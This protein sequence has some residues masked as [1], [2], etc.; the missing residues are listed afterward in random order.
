MAYHPE[1]PICTICGIRLEEPLCYLEEL[2]ERSPDERDWKNDV[3]ALSGPHWSPGESP[4][5]DLADDAVHRFDAVA[6][7]HPSVGL[8]LLPDKRS[9][10]TQSRYESDKPNTLVPPATM[11]LF[12]G[13]HAACEE[14]ANRVMRTSFN[15]RVRS[16]GHLWMTL[17]RRCARPM[18]R[19]PHMNFLP[20]LPE[21]QSGQPRSFGTGRYFVPYSCII[22][23]GDEW[24]GW[25]EDD[26]IV[27]PDLT[28]QLLSNLEPVSRTTGPLPSKFMQQFKGRLMTLPQ[29]LKNQLVSLLQEN[30][31]CLNCNYLMPQYL[32][33]QA[34]LQIP[35]LWDLHTKLVLEKAG[36]EPSETEEWNWEKITR[37]VLSPAQPPSPI[38]YASKKGYVWDYDKV[39]L[40]VPPGF[41][42]RR[43]IWQ[44]VEEMWP[45]DV[46]V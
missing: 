3:V 23:Y 8:V 32:W 21:S 46:G 13:I 37:Q 25:W 2:A 42:N 5:L 24:D 45:N 39:G 27:I 26:P 11:Q 33:K 34:F 38:S 44:I 10:D 16:I 15:A 28:T 9:V 36:S 1:Y 17:E 40:R 6:T 41:T 18:D 30:P 22:R 19:H 35:F 14:V 20:Y 12:M 29:E 7:W 43:R 4:S 31:V